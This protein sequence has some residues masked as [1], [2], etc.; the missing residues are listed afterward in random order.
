MTA[1][2]QRRQARRSDYNRIMGCHLRTLRR[3]RGIRPAVMIEGFG[4]SAALVSKVERGTRGPSADS[5]GMYCDVLELDPF[6]LVGDV[7]ALYRAEHGSFALADYLCV[8]A[9]LRA[10]DGLALYAGI[11]ERYLP[12]GPLRAAGR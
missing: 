8:P 1:H 2:M 4:I 12:A 9:R 7:A 10:L 11:P 3:E 6:D 5:L